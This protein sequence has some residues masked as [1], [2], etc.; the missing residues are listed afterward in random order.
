[1]DGPD[2]ALAQ[3]ARLLT[4]AWGLLVAVAVAAVGFA[5]FV[6]I[7]DEASH[8]D[9][10]DGLGTA[11][12]LWGL[13]FVTPVLGAAVATFAATR[14]GRRRYAAHQGAGTLRAVAVAS[15]CWVGLA[16]FVLV[17]MSPGQGLI[18]WMYLLVP[19]GLVLVPAWGILSSS[20]R[21]GRQKQGMVD[22]S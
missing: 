11:I 20:S 17:V 19:S 1:M 12:A 13:I 15:L 7:S 9:E 2:L 4:W 18:I 22:G 21:V 5:V 14:R 6:I 8:D 10:W 16:F 3:W